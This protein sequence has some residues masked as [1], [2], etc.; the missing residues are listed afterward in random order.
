MNPAEL[1]QRL[2]EY[3]DGELNPAE[4][5]EVEAYLRDH[6]A[7]RVAVERWRALRQCARRVLDTEAVPEGLADRVRA[8][9]TSA[10]GRHSA[11]WYRLGASGLAAAAVLV[12]AVFMWPRG[13]QATSIQVSGFAA[14]HR[15]C[16]LERRHD[17]FN[18]RTGEASGA[19]RQ[20]QAVE[21]LARQL[22]NL[23]AAGYQLDSVCRCGPPECRGCGARVLH[24][25][26]RRSDDQDVVVSSFVV[27]RSVQL[28]AADG[29]HCSKCQ[30]GGRCFRCGTDGDIT[31]VGWSDGR[32]SYLLAAHMPRHELIRLAEKLH[33]GG[34]WPEE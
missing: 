25:C 29:S 21:P 22:P 31:V 7:E 11:R 4:C 19:L 26:F 17:T 13:A 10:R 14:V 3:A 20:L 9:V 1:R 2:L 15:R 23:T 12:L 28:C 32:T 24:A 30:R 27:D 33:V 34:V 6:P 5:A 16:A 8:R 18:V